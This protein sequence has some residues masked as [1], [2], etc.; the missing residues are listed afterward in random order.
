MQ[1]E[2]EPLQP[3]NLETMSG[4]FPGTRSAVYQRV[5]LRSHRHRSIH[6]FQLH[7]YRDPF[8]A[9]LVA[10][11]PD[12]AAPAQIPLSDVTE[13]PSLL[14]RLTTAAGDAGYQLMACGACA[15]WQPT[16]LTNDDG[17]TLGRCR[18]RAPAQ[19]TGDGIDDGNDVPD[20][21]RL[22]SCLALD[23][24]HFVAATEPAPQ[25]AELEPDSLPET[26][27]LTRPRVPKSAELDPDRLPFWRRQWQRLR[28]KVEGPAKP[29]DDLAHGIIER[30]GVGAGTEPCFVCQGRIANLGALAV[31]SPEGD[32]QT[33]SVWRCRT[34]HTTYFNDWIDRWER[35]DSLETEERYY[36]IA[37]A[38]ALAALTLIQGVAGGDH[39]AGRSRRHALRSRLLSFVAQ[40]DP[41]SHQVRQGR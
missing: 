27:P 29:D 2:N 12:P 5:R 13:M 30:S 40:R 7:W 38:E 37:P 31:E 28:S 17:L 10:R 11:T 16:A 18:W 35:L 1:H 15:H 6:W 19:E 32:K 4:V 39:P 26:E 20:A 8:G 3:F 34:C 21:L 14:S 41:L 25:V 9:L 24:S 23:C 22:Q 33:L 36:R